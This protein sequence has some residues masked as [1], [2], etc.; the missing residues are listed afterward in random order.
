MANTCINQIKITGDLKDLKTI[1]DK[2]ENALRNGTNGYHRLNA[3]DFLSLFNVEKKCI[4]H[5]LREDI[6]DIDEIKDDV[7]RI[8]SESSWNFKQEIWRA[9]RTK[10]PEIKIYYLAEEF[11]NDVFETNDPTG[12][13]FPQKFALDYEQVGN[14]D[15]GIEYFNSEEDLLKFCRKTFKKRYSSAENVKKKLDTYLWK[16]HEDNFAVLHE[17]TNAD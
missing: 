8:W 12:T 5:D 17:I 11:G 10:F 16:Q 9:L 7:L 1:H 13:F 3:K 4:P 14:P 2:I 15:A 6:T